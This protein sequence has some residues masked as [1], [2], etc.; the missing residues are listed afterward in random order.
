[1]IRLVLVALAF[2]AALYVVVLLAVWRFQE[3]VVYQPPGGVAP[4]S[5]NAR[6]VRYR[7]ADGIDLFAYVV[8]DCTPANTIVLAF[9]GNAELARWSI[10]WALEVARVTRACVVIPEYRGYDGVVGTPTYS[11]SS[12]DARAALA[13][14]RD[15]LGATPERTVYFG[16]SLG[17]A[18]AAELAAYAAPRTLVLTA[19]FSSAREM[20]RRMFLPGLIAFWGMVSRVHFNTIDRVHTLDV[21]VW[22]AHGNTDFVIP[23]RMGREVFGAAK[24]Q[25]ELLIVPG[26]GHNDLPTRGGAEYWSWLRRAIESGAPAAATPRAAPAGTRLEP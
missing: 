8:G 20:G 10:P 22:V 4:A 14:V 23:V 24:H 15:S 21:P 25:G 3:R 5:V 17:T 2:T 16:H 9:H 1:V 6:Q 26:A 19:P 18:I 7:S 11:G 13:F 12:A